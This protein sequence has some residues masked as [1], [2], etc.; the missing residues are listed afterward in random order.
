MR[1]LI[2]LLLLA[3]LAI[4]HS[5]AQ[6]PVIVKN[7]YLEWLSI[8]VFVNAHDSGG[9]LVARQRGCDDCAPWVH[10]FDASVNVY[11]GTQTRTLA[12]LK[13]WRQF[14]GGIAVEKSSNRVVTIRRDY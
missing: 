14:P 1:K 4:S 7:Y 10:D 13:A 11:K 6:G 9:T 8:E 3:P 5:L 2:I 12:D